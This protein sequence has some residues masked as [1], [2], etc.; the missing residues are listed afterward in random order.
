[1]ETLATIPEVTG[2]REEIAP[3]VTAPM[4]SIFAPPVSLLEIRSQGTPS[5]IAPSLSTP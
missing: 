4:I 5:V 3:A 1:M 2:T